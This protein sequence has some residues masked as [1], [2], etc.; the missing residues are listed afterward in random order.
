[1]KHNIIISGVPRAGKTTLSRMLM[2]HGWTH[3][4]MDAIIA[5]FEQC[6]P[7]TG[8]STYQA[9]SSME[10]LRLISGKIAPFIRAM[11]EGEYSGYESE[12]A[13][14]DVY[15][16]LPEDY[17]KHLASANC[18]VYW[19][20]SSDC[21]AA[22]RFEI[23]KTYDTDKDYTF[24]KTETELREGCEYIV[25]QSLLLKHQCEIHGLPYR[26]TSFNREMVLNSILSDI[27][28]ETQSAP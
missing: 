16:L 21:S 8:V 17:C 9:L 19:I 1:M 23:Q 22:E 5:G 15:Q 4:S 11:I 6:F 12:R 25:E 14:F 18:M 26:D 2:Q 3:I 28:K 24:Y 27:L 10:T 13:V 20:G 7:E